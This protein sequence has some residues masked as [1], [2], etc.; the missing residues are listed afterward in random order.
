M[1]KII[2]TSKAVYKR[3]GFP[4]VEYERREMMVL[5]VNEW[6]TNHIK[7]IPKRIYCN[8]QMEIPLLVAFYNIIDR[9][10]VSELKTWD[11]CF[12]IR[13][14]RGYEQKY[15]RLIKEKK[16]D[17]AIQYLSLHAWGCAIDINAKENP[18]GKQPKMSREL[19]ECFTDAGF[20]WGG[21]FS[22]PD[23]MHFQLEYLTSK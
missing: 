15:N 5:N 13:S 20:D 11:G 14:I 16:F 22:R 21:T 19:V 2:L 3:F 12:N 23:G 7:V 4:D 8:K 9:N 1:E 6:I 17:E 18:L 10:L